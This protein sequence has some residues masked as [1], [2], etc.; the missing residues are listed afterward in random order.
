MSDTTTTTEPVGEATASGIASGITQHVDNP[1]EPLGAGGIESLRKERE[2]RKEAEAALRVAA[3][4]TE[5][6]E[7]LKRLAEA[8]SK[9]QAFEDA[10]KTEQEKAAARAEAAEKRAAEAEAKALR[11]EIASELNVPESLRKFLTATDDAGLRAQ[12]DEL[13]KALSAATA[14]SAPRQ[15]KPDPSQGAKPGSI[16]AQ[17]SKADLAG[18]TPQQINEALEA[19]R[20]V[21]VLAGKS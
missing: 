9:V 10:N 19:G 20:L 3:T 1:T 13:T 16:T 8:E 6:R 18:M 14:E 17:L 12:A 7:L 21:D 4:T 15:P 2:A 11:L 5:Q